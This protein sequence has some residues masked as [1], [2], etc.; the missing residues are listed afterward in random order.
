LSKP[1]GRGRSEGGNAGNPSGAPNREK[2]EAMNS[3]VGS[4]RDKR[5]G[6]KDDF[7]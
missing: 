7:P 4:F 6:F 5:N 3:V 1:R 2:G